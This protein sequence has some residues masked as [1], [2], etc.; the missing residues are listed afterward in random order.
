LHQGFSNGQRHLGIVG[1]ACRVAFRLLRAI[2]RK[3]RKDSIYTEKFG[4]GA[5]RIA[6]CKAEE[7][8]GSAS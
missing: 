3:A 8:A 1:Y 7:T 2:G 5:E 6:E 4:W